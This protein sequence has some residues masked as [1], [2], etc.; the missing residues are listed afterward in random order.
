M[1]R[2]RLFIWARARAI[3]LLAGYYVQNSTVSKGLAIK[4]LRGY[5][6]LELK[7]RSVY[8]S[9]RFDDQLRLSNWNDTLSDCAMADG[10]QVSTSQVCLLQPI[11]P[12]SS[13][14]NA[15]QRTPLEAYFYGH[16]RLL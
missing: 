4:L 16:Q 3:I 14:L 9:C 10:V 15:C 8:L 7:L 13:G 11:L 12:T 1:T 2:L 5:P 6:G